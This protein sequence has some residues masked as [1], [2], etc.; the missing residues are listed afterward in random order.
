[1]GK[2]FVDGVMTDQ[3]RHELM[4]QSEYFVRDMLRRFRPSQEDGVPTGDI[5]RI[6]T[7][8]AGLVAQFLWEHE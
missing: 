7:H 2:L 8:V 1:M 6:A 5:E 3:A 4:A